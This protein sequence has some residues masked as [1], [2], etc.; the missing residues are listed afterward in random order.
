MSVRKGL[1]PLRIFLAEI[2]DTC[3]W[4]LKVRIL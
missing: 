1:V 3:K 4:A 2:N